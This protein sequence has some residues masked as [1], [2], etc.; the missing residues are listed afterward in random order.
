MVKRFIDVEGKM[1]FP[2]AG[3]QRCAYTLSGSTD[4]Y[5]LK[6]M[7]EHGG[8]P[9]TVLKFYDYRRRRIICL[10]EQKPNVMYS[11]P[12]YYRKYYYFLQ[13]DYGEG[14]VR[15]CKWR[16]DVAM[17]VVTELAL[18]GI[19]LYNL[20]LLGDVPHVISQNGKLFR[21][22]YPVAF[23]I[24][25][26]PNETACFVDDGRVYFEAWIEEGWDDEH[27]CAG[28]DYKFYDKVIVKNFEGNTISEELGSLSLGP[29]GAWW[30][31]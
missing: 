5:E 18:E 13:C 25:I 23:S 31:S 16:P 7:E 3:Q 8:H 28:P 22:Y 30:I 17:T 2:I 27:D 15:L 19:D 26:R 10:F 4:F 20:Q 1:L 9:G 14:A 29:D 21:C 12:L 6:E 11:A 24:P